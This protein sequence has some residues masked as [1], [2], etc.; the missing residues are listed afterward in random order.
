MIKL[1]ELLLSTSFLTQK[2]NLQQILVESWMDN[3]DGDN[4]QKINGET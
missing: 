2:K 1:N 4:E 3:E